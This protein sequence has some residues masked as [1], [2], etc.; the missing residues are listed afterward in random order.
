MLAAKG[1]SATS[2][3]GKEPQ[4]VDYSYWSAQT[5]VSVLAMFRT[6]RESRYSAKIR[7]V[8]SYPRICGFEISEM[9]ALVEVHPM[10]LSK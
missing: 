10:S 5:V 2:E 7:S 1:A 9:A 3:E 6:E 8:L 4:A